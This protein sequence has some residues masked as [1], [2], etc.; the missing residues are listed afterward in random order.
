MK[1]HVKVLGHLALRPDLASP[2]LIEEGSIL[3]R[4][5]VQEHIVADECCDLTTH[6]CQA[7]ALVDPARE[8]GN[9]ALKVL[10]VNLHDV[11]FM[12]N[13]C[14]LGGLGHFARSVAEAVL[15]HDGVR[16]DDEDDLESPMRGA[17]L[18]Q[19]QRC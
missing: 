3:K 9:D 4:T 7:D 14:N 6:A 8:V 12:L 16:V 13:D 19:G 17:L 2:A 18:P 10:P 11:G 1:R 5:P 15:R